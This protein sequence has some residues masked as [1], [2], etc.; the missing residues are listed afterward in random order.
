MNHV[1][2]YKKP[3][4]ATTSGLGSVLYTMIPQNKGEVRFPISLNRLGGDLPMALE[5]VSPSVPPTP[6]PSHLLHPRTRRVS[7]RSPHTPR[8]LRMHSHCHCIPLSRK[9]MVLFPCRDF[10]EFLH[11]VSPTLHPMATPT[12]SASGEMWALF[13]TR[14]NVGLCS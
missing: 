13:C 7:S 5:G 8:E 12:S 3:A 6:S 2:L 4:C 10:Q 14:T 11:I 9:D 1:V